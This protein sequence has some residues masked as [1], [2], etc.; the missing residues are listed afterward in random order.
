MLERLILAFDGALRAVAGV[1]HP[2]RPTPGGNLPEAE[3]A[4]VERA[5]VI[6]LM[7]VNHAG[8]VC[9]Q[10]LYHGQALLARDP[11]LRRELDISA[12]EEGDHL[13]WTRERLRALGGR[14]SRLDPFWYAGA[15]GIG[16]AAA[17]LGDRISLG[18]LKET[19][20][21]VVAH[22]EGH[23]ARLPVADAVSREV[24][25]AMRDDEGAHAAK[26]VRLG[27][28]DFPLPVR[29]AMRAS[30]KVMTGVAY[31]L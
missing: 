8:E 12:A 23:L 27:A 4:P 7:R 11:S 15:F 18:F 16:V 13:H 14:T 5:T 28:A 26:A 2:A 9:A 17:A 24:L 29:L 19:E 25:E 21:Q 22:L 1:T 31:Y 3:L 6:A 20:D 10:A 30:A